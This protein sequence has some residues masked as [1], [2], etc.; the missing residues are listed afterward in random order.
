[1]DRADVTGAGLDYLTAG[2]RPIFQ[3]LDAVTIAFYHGKRHRRTGYADELLNK[4]RVLKIPSID[5]LESQHIHPEIES[6]LQRGNGYAGM[7]DTRDRDRRSRR[8]PNRANRAN[9]ANQVG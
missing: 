5:M 4:G 7:S 1:M 8:H 2:R 6:I 3:Q 9:R